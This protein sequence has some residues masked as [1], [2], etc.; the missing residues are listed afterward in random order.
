MSK[1]IVMHSHDQGI[2]S[3]IVESEKRPTIKQVVRCLDLCFEPSKAEQIE[4]DAIASLEPTV[5]DW[6][7]GDD[8]DF[9]EDED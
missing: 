6:Q 8:E 2:S 5:L 3:F 7:D 4:I 9:E 1:Y